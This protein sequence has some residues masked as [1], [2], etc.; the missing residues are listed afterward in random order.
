MAHWNSSP[1]PISDIRDWKEAGRLAARGKRGYS[2]VEDRVSIVTCRRSSPRRIGPI[3]ALRGPEA[4]HTPPA[5][6]QEADQRLHQRRCAALEAPRRAHARQVPH[7]QPEID[8]ADLDEQPF[9]DVGMP[10]QMDA[11]HSAGLVEMRVGP[12]Q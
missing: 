2:S 9:Q 6:A 10:A 7:E 11:A 5:A 12:F 8:A 4:P 3:M 1:H